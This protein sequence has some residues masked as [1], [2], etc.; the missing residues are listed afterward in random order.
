[1]KIRQFSIVKGLYG[2]PVIFVI[3]KSLSELE[4]VSGLEALVLYPDFGLVTFQLFS[5][6]QIPQIPMTG[7]E[8]FK[9][10]LSWRKFSGMSTIF[11]TPRKAMDG[12]RCWRVGI[13][14]IWTIFE[15]VLGI[16]MS[17]GAT[18]AVSINLIRN[19]TV[20]TCYRLSKIKSKFIPDVWL[21]AII[22]QCI[23]LPSHDLA[24][25]HFPTR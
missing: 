14:N 1:M 3:G 22:C 15:R 5:L 24:S 6:R 18:L 16:G 23:C 21:S 17:F 10:I 19:S 2:R 9:P 12:R 25:S 11:S 4:R 8:S 13:Q 20:L 7:V